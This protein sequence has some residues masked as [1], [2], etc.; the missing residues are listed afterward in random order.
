MGENVFYI[1]N[2]SIE[3]IPKTKGEQNHVTVFMG[4][5][6]TTAGHYSLSGSDIKIGLAFNYNRNESD[7]TCYSVEEL[8]NLL[9]EQQIT[10]QVVDAGEISFKSAINELQTGEKY[11]RICLILAL[12]FLATEIALI[13]LLK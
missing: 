9:T 3:I 12:I 13:K 7:L 11:W 8:N 2:E 1:K 6:I 4:N 5:E 10:A